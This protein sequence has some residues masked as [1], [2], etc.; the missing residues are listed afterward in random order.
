MAVPNIAI[1]SSQITMPIAAQSNAAFAQFALL[2]LVLLPNAQ[3]NNIISPT[4]GI[5]VRNKVR[6]QSEIVTG[7]CGCCGCCCAS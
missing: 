3:T 1:K 4:S 5:A 7:C 2:G 6:N